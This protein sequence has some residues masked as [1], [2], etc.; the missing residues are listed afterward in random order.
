VALS[1][2]QPPPLDHPPYREDHPDQHEQQ[3]YDGEADE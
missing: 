3:T 1:V 2:H